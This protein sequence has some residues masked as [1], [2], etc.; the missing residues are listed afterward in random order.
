MTEGSPGSFR[1]KQG[2]LVGLGHLL[3][4]ALAG[5][6]IGLAALLVV[7]AV[8]AWL[9]VSRFGRANGWLAVVLPVWL[10]VDEFRAWRGQPGRFTPAFVGAL[11]ALALGSIATGLASRLPPLA[12]GAIGAAV[13]VLAYSLVWF[14]GIRWAGRR[15]GGPRQ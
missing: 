6:V 14:Y 5:F 2:R 10:L 11:V 3:G 15:S 8:L 12:S 9:D 4:F 1:N 13:A 7:D